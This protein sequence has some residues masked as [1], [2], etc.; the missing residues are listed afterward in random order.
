MQILYASP[1]STAA[2]VAAANW[3]ILMTDH[4]DLYLISIPRQ[5]PWEEFTWVRL[6]RVFNMTQDETLMILG[7]VNFQP[8]E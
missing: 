5:P 2:A 8:Y 7:N 6:Y 4:N 1:S 3:P